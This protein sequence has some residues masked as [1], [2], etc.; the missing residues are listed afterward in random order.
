MQASGSGSPI[1]CSPRRTT[2]RDAARRR[3]L[4]RLLADVLE[5][6]EERARHLAL[7]AEAPERQIAVALEQAADAAARRGAPDV[8]A[9]LLEDAARL[10]PLDAAE[11]RRSRTIVAAEQHYASGNAAGPA[12]CSNGSCPSCPVGRPE[13]GRWPNSRLRNR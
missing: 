4:H 2:E 3:E 6:E 13:R 11:A 9:L 5:D 12:I 7:G 8:A 1:R 10:T